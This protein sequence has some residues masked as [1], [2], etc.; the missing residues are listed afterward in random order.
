M[1]ATSTDSISLTMGETSTIDSIS[2]V[3]EKLKKVYSF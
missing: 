3:N 2:G 1:G